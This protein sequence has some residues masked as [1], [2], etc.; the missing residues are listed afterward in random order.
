MVLNEIC[1]WHREE[2]T[3]GWIR[4]HDVSC[5][6]VNTNREIGWGRLRRAN[7]WHASRGEET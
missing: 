6:S 2:E 5:F 7:K 3:G 4:Q 1:G